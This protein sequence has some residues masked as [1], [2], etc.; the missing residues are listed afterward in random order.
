VPRLGEVRGHSAAHIAQP[1]EC[2]ACHSLSFRHPELVSGSISTPVQ[3][4]ATMD[5]ETSSA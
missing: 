3:S 2:D 5:A 4:A 1:N